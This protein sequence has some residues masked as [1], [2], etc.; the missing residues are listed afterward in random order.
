MLKG[1]RVSSLIEDIPYLA[2]FSQIAISPHWTCGNTEVSL[3]SK[4]KLDLKLWALK[5]EEKQDNSGAA[6]QIQF[7]PKL[8]YSPFSRRFACW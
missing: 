1:T 8:S 2:P 6:G 5:T 7:L 3:S 4:K